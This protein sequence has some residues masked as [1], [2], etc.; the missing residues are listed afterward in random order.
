MQKD[1]VE[2]LQLIK[3]K[4]KFPVQDWKKRGLNPS[5]DSVRNKMNEDVNQFI[6]FVL[7]NLTDNTISTDAIQTYLDEWDSYDFDTEETEYVVDTMFQILRMVDVD[8]D[9]ILI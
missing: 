8:V 6:E 3:A 7:S 9:D 5:P 2:Q 4:D 1:I